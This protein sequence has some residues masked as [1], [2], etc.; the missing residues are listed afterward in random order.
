VTQHILS[1]TDPSG[2]SLR[3]ELRVGVDDPEFT[4]E[5]GGGVAYRFNLKSKDIDFRSGR[6][7]RI[8]GPSQESWL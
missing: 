5:A 7:Q 2:T 6:S 3:L 8:H 4:I 1:L